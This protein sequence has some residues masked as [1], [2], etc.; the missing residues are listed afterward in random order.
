MKQNKNNLIKLD[1]SS[2]LERD[3]SW[4]YFNYRII[5]EAMNKDVP[6]LERLTFLG[7]CSNNLDEFYKVRVASLKRIAAST[8]KN[9]KKEKIKAK[10]E[11][12]KILS[13]IEKYN[14]DFNNTLNEI[15]LEL[16]NHGVYL[17]NENELSDNQILYLKQYY[18]DNIALNINPI[19]LHKKVNLSSV[20]DT[21]IYLAIKMEE[22]LKDELND[23]DY[24]LIALPVHIV[25]RFI[26]LLLQKIRKTV[27]F[28]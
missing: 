18:D 24:A 27:L 13:L 7:I 26:K 19:M 25:G 5:K 21:H 20:N 4:C 9:F 3:I 8:S 11:V 16:R 22:K 23:I 28:I 1:F 6:L 17:L 12:K 14:I 10:K 2:Y 15:F